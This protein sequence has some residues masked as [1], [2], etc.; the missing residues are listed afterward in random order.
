MA[1]SSSQIASKLF[2]KSL[3]AGET[4]ISRQ[5]FEEPRLGRD[6]ILSDQVWSQSGLIPTTAPTLAPGASAGVVQYFQF[7]TLTHVSGSDNL[8]Y[9]SSNLIDSIPFNFGD[10]TYNYQIYKNDGITTIAFGEGD[11]LVDNTAGLLTFYGTLPSGVNSTSPPKI[12]FYKYVGSKGVGSGS[13]IGTILGV[14]AGYGLTGGGT[15]GFLSM[16]INIDNGLKFGGTGGDFIQV[17]G[18]TGLGVDI[19]GVYILDSIAGNG[20][21]I[22]SGVLSVDTNDLIVQGSGLTSSGLTLSLAYNT[23]SLEISNNYLGLKSTI[24]GNRTFQDSVTVNGDF[25]VNGT[26]SYISTQNLLVEDNIIIL[27]AT[28]SGPSILNSGIEVNRGGVDLNSVL[29][30]NEDQKLWTAGLSGSTSPILLYVDGGLTSSGATISII[31]TNVIS[32]S[33]GSQTEVSTFTVN[34]RGQLTFATSSLISIPSSQ[35]SNFTQS[36]EGVVFTDNNFIDGITVTFSVSNG[37]SVTAEVSLGSLT[38]SRFDISNP[39]SASHGWNLGYNL[40]GKFEWFDPSLVGDITSVIAGTGLNGGGNSGELILGV[41]LGQN[42]G[43]TFSGDDVVI[44]SN[45]AG[46]SLT[47][48]NGVLDVVI[49]NNSGLTYSGDSIIIDT[50]IAGNGLDINNGVL[51]INNSEIVSTL[52][53]N[54]LTANGSSLDV[55][56]GN[57]LSINSDV[58]GLGGTLSQNTTID[59]NQFDLFLSNFDNLQ[60]V[61]SSF[62]V[63]ADGLI[64]MDA[65]TGSVQISADDQITLISTLDDISILS[66]KN[67]LITTSASQITTNSLKGL[68]YTSDYSNTFVGNSLITK[69]YVDSGTSSIW[70]AIGSI[71]GDFITGVTA[72]IGLTGGG[73][74]GFVT[75]STDIQVESGLTFSG[76]KVSINVDNKTVGVISD[77]I[78]VITNPVYSQRNKTPYAT[79]LGQDGQSA[80]LTV[81][82]TPIDCSFVS[83]YVNG[84]LQYLGDGASSSV[85]CY[86][87]NDGGVT[88]KNIF[89]ISIGDT[90]YWNSSTNGGFALS[91]TDKIDIIYKS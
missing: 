50:N 14:T 28:Y 40:S 86:F 30:W 64:S 62:D 51:T 63:I 27:N 38:S 25:T 60:V 32:G 42:S 5:F 61:S 24:I 1:L 2:K 68:E 81:S 37:N 8:S 33:Y 59:G 87:S 21:N 36:V 7:E 58:I 4:I 44:D 39:G 48:T 19:N 20:L 6:L 43:L 76:N 46:K 74:S 89:D 91:L 83:V 22:S 12:T 55:N 26:V 90:L 53:G 78:S 13:G 18:S 65:G 75:L 34:S 77:Q 57:G 67:L 79:I 56:I 29:L 73:S 9:F 69:T 23:D 72:G 17:K 52:S 70:S 41:N 31:N 71:S 84:L 66:Y 85:D 45:I 3:G 35:V 11:W 47:L 54:G 16:D 15:Q 80:G 88:A 82:F 49:G 10:G